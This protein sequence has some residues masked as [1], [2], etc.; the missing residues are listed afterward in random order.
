MSFCHKAGEREIQKHLGVV[1]LTVIESFE[2]YTGRPPQRGARYS[3][4]SSPYNVE[5][6]ALAAEKAGGSDRG[7]V[8]IGGPCRRDGRPT[9]EAGVDVNGREKSGEGKEFCFK[10][11]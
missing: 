10:D 8:R 7:C 2:L 4:S 9:G 6:V 5:I 11:N 1:Y 3:T